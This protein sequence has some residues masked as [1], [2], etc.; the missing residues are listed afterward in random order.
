[1]VLEFDKWIC[2]HLQWGYIV[3]CLRSFIQRFRCFVQ[4][5][6]RHFVQSQ[7]EEVAAR[8]C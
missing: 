1:M 2:I 6:H 7:A 5:C 3:R 4:W 8:S